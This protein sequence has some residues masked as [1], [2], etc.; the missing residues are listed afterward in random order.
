MFT[1]KKILITSLLASAMMFTA[2]QPQ[3]DAKKT[4][5]E[6]SKKPE[7]NLQL[8]GETQKLELNLPPCKGSN[9][10]DIS[11]E[12]LSSN[13]PFIDKIIDQHII[14]LLQQILPDSEMASA[15]NVNVAVEAAASDAKQETIMT[16]KQSFEKQLIPFRN[17]MITYDQEL[18]AL[19]SSHT[20]SIMIKPKILSSDGELVTVV[21]NGS[22]YLG[23][24][25]G[26]SSQQYFNFSLKQKKLVTLKDIIE[27]NQLPALKEKAYQAF[28]A[29]IVDSQLAQDPQE[30]EQMW[31]F[32]LSHNYYLTSQGLILQY[33]E[34][35]IGPYVAGL[36]R[37]IIPY[38]AL[39]GILKPQYFPQNFVEAEASTVPSSEIK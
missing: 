23:G 3:Q 17:A 15:S 30:Y 25:H 19:N 1:N 35:Q 8:I 31:K 20:I 7:Q 11:I 13:Q 27:K 5:A 9:C 2:C 28:K 6:Q 29:W 22:E 37:L 12:R 16:P 33:A 4:E 26:S 24:A 10:P 34:Y 39:Q 14:E 21:L 38:Q 36:P 32:E 18:K